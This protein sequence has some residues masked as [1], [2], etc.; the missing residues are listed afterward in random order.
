MNQAAAENYR[1]RFRRV[2]DYIDARIDQHLPLE[3]LSSVAAFSKCHFQRQFTGL[4][5]IGVYRYI[6]LIRLKRASFQLA[7]RED[8][9]VLDIALA[10]GYGGPEAF[11]RAFRKST[12]QS[13]SEFR[14][15]PKWTAWHAA[16]R[17][18]SE[19][20][21]EHMK[22]Q[23]RAEDVRVVQFPETKVATF[24]HRGDPELIGDSIRKFIAWRKQNNLPPKVS[25]TFN[26]AYDNP[27]ETAPEDYRF[28]LCAATER[29]VEPNAFGI[30]SRT[31]P[32][33]RCAVL[34]HIGSDDRLGETVDYLYSQWLPGSGEEP[35]DFP[36]FFQRISFF[37]EVPESEALTD[38]FLPLAPC[39]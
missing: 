7:Y 36:L 23:Y 16:Y 30:V 18:L 20:R 14:R 4:F 17:P 29:D 3:R 21:I 26:V 10:S 19:L 1:L 39:Q 31:I 35:G 11:A 5:G 6:Q 22:P 25:A 34:R 12:G 27:A 37:P 38:V 28:D 8:M 24:E 9:A 15:Q 13:P 2:L 33:G 32:G